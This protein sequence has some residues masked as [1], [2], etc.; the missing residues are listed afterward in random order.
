MRGY[1][2]DCLINYGQYMLCIDSILKVK[3]DTNVEDELVHRIWESYSTVAYGLGGMVVVGVRV[4]GKEKILN[5]T[6]FGYSNNI[7]ADSENII[8]NKQILIDNI[9][10]DKHINTFIV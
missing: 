4:S 1:V 10:D 5:L 8:A 9:L 3:V 2:V 6:E 7:V